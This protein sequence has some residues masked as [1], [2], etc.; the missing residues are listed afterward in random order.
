MFS[1]RGRGRFQLA[2]FKFVLWPC[3]WVHMPP[4][5]MWYFEMIQMTK[6]SLGCSFEAPFLQHC[7][8]LNSL[9]ATWQFQTP[10]FEYRLE[11]SLLL[12]EARPHTIQGCTP[13]P[14]L[15][16]LNPHDTCALV[17]RLRF[18]HVFSP[19]CSV[20]NSVV[21]KSTIVSSWGRT[22]LFGSLF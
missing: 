22:L 11:W 16:I 8:V 10:E 6:E 7:S 19:H 13:A 14:L 4:F 9:C 21:R 12:F 5:W 17:G 2:V 3:M 18:D 1:T 15:T 20:F